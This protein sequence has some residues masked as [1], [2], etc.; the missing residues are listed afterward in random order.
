MKTFLHY[1][2]LSFYFDVEK[3]KVRARERE[4]EREDGSIFTIKNFCL[5]ILMQ[6]QRR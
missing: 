5:F 6:R 4:R 3:K 1:N 2:F